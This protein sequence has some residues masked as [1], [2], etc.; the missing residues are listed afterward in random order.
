MKEITHLR[1]VGVTA[2]DPGSLADF[3]ERVWGLRRVADQDGAVYLTAAGDEH[4]VL[5]IYPSRGPSV[6]HI[7]LGM[8]DRDAVDEAARELG[9]RRGIVIVQGPGEMQEPGGGYGVRIGDV[10]GRIIELSAE[11]APAAHAEYEAA[12]KPRKLSHVVLNSPKH[13][14]YEELLTEVLGFRVSDEMPHM[15]FF[16]CNPDHHSVALA[17]A[18]HASLNHIAFE[19]PTADDVVRG[20]GHM[21]EHEFPAL[22]GPGR[23]GPGDNAFG[24]FRAPNGQVIEYTAELE[25]IEADEE[26]EPRFWGPGAVELRDPWSDPAQTRPSGEARKAMLGDPEPPAAGPSEIDSDGDG[27]GDGGQGEAQGDDSAEGRA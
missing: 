7:S 8:A 16:R 14:A 11:V 18:P 26:H 13:A 2:P 25:Q 10:D 27:D 20:V 22:W 24:Y 23:H 12:M 6:R 1:R 15:K 9:R 5:V 21:A 19:V 4:H 3:Y 17:K